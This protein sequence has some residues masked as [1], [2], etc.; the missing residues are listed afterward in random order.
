M[1]SCAG[2]LTNQLAGCWPNYVRCTKQT[3]PKPPSPRV[4]AQK[5]LKLNA[6]ALILSQNNPSGLSDS[7]EAGRTITRRLSDGPALIDV[8]VLDHLVVSGSGFTSLAERRLSEL[9]S[10]LLRALRWR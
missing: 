10:R 1:A 6:C 8:R 3:A 9:L 5:Y 7:S 2:V 4:V